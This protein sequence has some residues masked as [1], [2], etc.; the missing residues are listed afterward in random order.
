MAFAQF[1]R[2]RALYAEARPDAAAAF[3]ALAAIAMLFL[4]QKQRSILWLSMGTVAVLIGF[5]FKQTSAAAALV[6]LVAAISLR[7]TPF[8]TQLLLSLVPGATLALAIFLMRFLWYPGYYYLIE[9]PRNFSLQQG[10]SM[11][12]LFYLLLCNKLF[13]AAAA[14]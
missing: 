3:F 13:I 7:P 6:P 14:F 11:Q 1:F 12:V 4:A 5:F 10:L 2:C 9:V 8:R